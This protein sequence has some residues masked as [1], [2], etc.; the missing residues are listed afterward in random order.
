M[1]YVTVPDN[2]ES[3]AVT[4]NR[5]G[6]RVQL[7]RQNVLIF[8]SW[9][10]S[11]LFNYHVMFG[12]VKETLKV[13]F[14]FL[15]SSIK[16]PWADLSECKMIP[17]KR[18]SRW[19][20]IYSRRNWPSPKSNSFSQVLKINTKWKREDLCRC[21]KRRPWMALEA[22]YWRFAQCE[23]WTRLPCFC[24]WTNWQSSITSFR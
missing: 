2:L 16:S 19:S 22:C 8:M 4:Q 3:V 7:P 17:K 14:V 12:D 18:S 1:L 23:W 5:K 24:L 9:N 20:K 15:W 11:N 21:Q 10:S 13:L 6:S